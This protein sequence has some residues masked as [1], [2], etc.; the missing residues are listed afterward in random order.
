M[1][2]I[3]GFPRDRIEVINN[4]VDVDRFRPSGVPKTELRRQLGLPAEGLLI[5]MVARFVPFKDHAGVLHAVAGLLQAKIETR[6]A[7]VGS[8][9]LGDELRR[10][11]HELEIADRVHFL[12]ELDR[13]ERFLNALDVF[14]SNSSHNEGLSLAILEAMA[15]DVP[16]VA[17][18]VAAHAEVLD[19]G[20]AGVLIPP[21][22]TPSLVRALR[23]LADDPHLLS[24]L[25]RTG[26]QRIQDHYTLASMVESYRQL[27][28]QL[29]GLPEKPLCPRKNEAHTC[30]RKEYSAK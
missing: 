23:Q 19:E 22:D 29:A 21:R 24:S 2:S 25:G 17:T 6:L 18:R 30:A 4:S 12:G 1:T 3:V 15:C 26:R 5:G 20:N 11:A 7:L 8:G 9:P 28:I 16:V 27:Y 14:V 13:V 10:L